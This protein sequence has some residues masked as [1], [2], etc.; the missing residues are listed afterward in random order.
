[1]D[2]PHP[3]PTPEHPKHTFKHGMMM[4][5]QDGAVLQG[6]GQTVSQEQQKVGVQCVVVFVFPANQVQV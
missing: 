5:V 6:R 3:N 4:R 2:T 1:M